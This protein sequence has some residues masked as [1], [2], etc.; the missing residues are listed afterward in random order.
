[1]A[2]SLLKVEH[3]SAVLGPEDAVVT[4]VDDVSWELHEGEVLG[5]VGESGSGKS[6]SVLSLLGLLPP[7]VRIGGGQVLYD[8]RDLVALSESELR[9]VR[10]REIAMIFQDPMTSF[11]PVRTI[12]SQ[13]AEA[14]R[15]HDSSLGRR[16][17]RA[18]AVE[19]LTLVGVPNAAMRCRQYPSEFSGG[20]RQRAMLA[21]AMANEPRILI[22]DEPTTALDVTTQA[23]VLDLLRSLQQR[24]SAAIIFISHDLEVVAEICDRVLVMYAGRIVESGATRAVLE[25]PAHPY[26][27]ALLSARPRLDGQR[28][29]RLQAIGGQPPNL[30]ELSTGCAFCERCARGRNE[31]VC[32]SERPGLEPIAEEREAAC[33]F[34]AEQMRDEATR[35]Q[36]TSGG[37][38]RAE[39]GARGAAGVRR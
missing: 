9:G 36:E 31:R 34:A 38:Q 23:Q 20:M 12:G 14:M 19:L 4:V 29:A 28:G 5:I 15:I 11:N 21:M 13:I 30:A 16:A 18:R 27:R 32:R 25:R 17:A 33:H 35:K 8:G 10:G 39:D 37:D 3:L 24:S 22:A 7:S 1:V 26:T 6:L 2:V